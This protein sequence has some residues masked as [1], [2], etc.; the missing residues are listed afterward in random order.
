MLNEMYSIITQRYSLFLQIF[1]VIT[2]EFKEKIIN[3]MLNLSIYKFIIVEVAT[4]EIYLFM[5]DKE[6]ECSYQLMLCSLKLIIR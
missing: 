6:K 3:F 4:H 5:K 1:Q 2:S